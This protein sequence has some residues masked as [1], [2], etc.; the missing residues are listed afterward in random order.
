MTT[1]K[2]CG[3][4]GLNQYRCNC[5]R[6]T[7]LKVKA[8]LQAICRKGAEKSARTK[9]IQSFHRWAALVKGKS[10]QEAWRFVY[11][12]GYANGYEARKRRH[13]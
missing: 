9:R 1:C 5:K 4:S 11:Q 13:A 7:S 8:H 3:P 12:Q 10:V 6:R 2:V